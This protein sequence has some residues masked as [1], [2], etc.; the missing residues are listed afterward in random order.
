MVPISTINSVPNLA[1]SP[2]IRNA[3]FVHKSLHPIKLY[4]GGAFD[5]ISFQVVSKQI[6]SK[7]ISVS[8]SN[9][10]HTLIKLIS[11]NGKTRASGHGNMANILSAPFPIYCQ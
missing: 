2:R 5:E 4:F 10:I 6:L 11:S 7:D 3:F 8:L 1:E 9:S